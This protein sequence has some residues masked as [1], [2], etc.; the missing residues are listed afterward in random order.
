MQTCYSP[1]M[2]GIW[3]VSWAFSASP[4]KL[5][6]THS[7]EQLQV[8]LLDTSSLVWRPR[9]WMA[10]HLGRAAQFVAIKSTSLLF[11]QVLHCLHRWA[12]ITSESGGPE[13]VG[14]EHLFSMNSARCPRFYWSPCVSRVR[15]VE[16]EQQKRG[17]KQ[18]L[19]CLWANQGSR[20][21]SCDICAQVISLGL[22]TWDF[23]QV[24]I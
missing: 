20:R 4:W 9:F 5:Q 10:R 14:Q 12:C 22:S 17:F 13:E 23:Y 19:H 2:S 11:Y 8:F 7:A 24:I 16:T 21:E 1:H 15:S 18:T 6:V 3:N